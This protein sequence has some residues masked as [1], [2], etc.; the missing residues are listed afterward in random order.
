MK[1]SVW[2]FAHKYKIDNG[3]DRKQLTLPISFFPLFVRLPRVNNAGLLA[4]KQYVIPELSIVRMG[5]SLFMR[6][7][8]N[9]LSRAIG[10]FSHP[11]KLV[12]TVL[13]LS[14]HF[15]PQLPQPIV[16]IQVSGWPI[17]FILRPIGIIR[18]ISRVTCWVITWRSSG[19]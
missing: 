13:C 15:V 16:Q 19:T 12:D 14:T 6:V 1:S 3:E 7:W 17:T 18:I 5:L 9:L 8:T 11:I 4:L 10:T 2:H